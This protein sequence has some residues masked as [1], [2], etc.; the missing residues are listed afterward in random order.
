MS[1][2]RGKWQ[3]L[4]ASEDDFTTYTYIKKKICILTLKD[5]GNLIYNF[6]K[7][8]CYNRT[9]NATFNLLSTYCNTNKY[10]L[11]R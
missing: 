9:T 7:L 4:T 6:L 1:H 11:S 2:S 8:P 3:N 5:K 10:F